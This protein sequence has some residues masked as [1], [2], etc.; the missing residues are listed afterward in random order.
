MLVGNLGVGLPTM[1]CGVQVH[2]M[3]CGF[4]QDGPNCLKRLISLIFSRPKYDIETLK[5]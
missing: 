3:T 2:D 5:I 1:S 4:L